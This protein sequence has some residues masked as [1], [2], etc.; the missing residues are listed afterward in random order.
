M[1]SRRNV[2]LFC[3]VSLFLL[4]AAAEDAHPPNIVY[5]MADDLGF[6]GVG[7]NGQQVYNTPQI[8]HLSR[9]GMILNQFYS[10]SPVCAPTRCTLMTGLHTGHA[11]IRD[12]SGTR[13]DGYATV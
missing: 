5:I 11:S 10:G 1:R 13:P 8:D 6:G 3:F 12:N 2:L 4:S 7:Y 9:E